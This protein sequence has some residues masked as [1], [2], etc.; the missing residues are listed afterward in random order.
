MGPNRLLGGKLSI[1]PRKYSGP[2]LGSIL[3]SLLCRRLRAFIGPNS[4]QWALALGSLPTLGELFWG[5]GPRLYPQKNSLRTSITLGSSRRCFNFIGSLHPFAWGMGSSPRPPCAYGG[6]RR[7]H[8]LEDQVRRN[9]QL[10]TTA[11]IQRSQ[12]EKR[13]H[14]ANWSSKGSQN[15]D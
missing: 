15:A 5:M 13:S 12:L 11:K 9:G 4:P 1:R 10:E 7:K 2:L 8:Q 6:R 3:V 14:G